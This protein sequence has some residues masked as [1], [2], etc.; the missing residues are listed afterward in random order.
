MTN[1]VKATKILFS[2]YTLEQY[3]ATKGDYSFWRDPKAEF[4]DSE[5]N[6]MDL[7]QTKYNRLGN[8]DIGKTLK[9]GPVTWRDLE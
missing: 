2:Q 4:V 5:G 3:S 6:L 8:L 1:I 7:V 9:R